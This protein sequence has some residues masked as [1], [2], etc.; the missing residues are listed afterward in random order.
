MFKTVKEGSWLSENGL[1]GV[2]YKVV[3]I[4]E[5]GSYAQEVWVTRRGIG[6]EHVRTKAAVPFYVKEMCD[7]Y[8]RKCKECVAR[9]VKARNARVLT[10]KADNDSWHT[11]L[12]LCEKVDRKI[13]H[14]NESTYFIC[15]DFYNALVVG[16]VEHELLEGAV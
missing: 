9:L 3:L 7:K 2:E 11:V 15:N 8:K 16:E 12:T 4:K 5:L 14:L 10:A 13:F 1:W 6:E